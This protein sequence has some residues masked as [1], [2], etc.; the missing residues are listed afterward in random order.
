MP[1]TED[2][3]SSRTYGS[4]PGYT[5][6]EVVITLVILGL[7]ALYAFPRI[8]S[9][10]SITLRSQA[11]K[12]ASDLRRAQIL[13][14]ARGA[15]LCVRID[16]TTSSY[17]VL[18]PSVPAGESAPPIVPADCVDASALRD[19]ITNQLVDGVLVNEVSLTA[20]LAADLVFN[21]LGQPSVDVVYTLAPKGAE[22]QGARIQVKVEATTGRVS[23][24]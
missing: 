8:P 16:P 2:T 21:S 23:V 7:V 15:S 5:L 12:F 11:E 20:D 18:V 1:Q 14:T 10:D 17:S 4:Q 22:A 6:I 3:K 9:T 24:N 13:A 19:P